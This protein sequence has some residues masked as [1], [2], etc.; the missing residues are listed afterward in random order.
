MNRYFGSLLL[1]GA[2]L[3]FAPRT[4]LAVTIETVIVGNPGNTPDFLYAYGP[5]GAVGYSYRIG[6][7]EV[8]N[9]Q[10]TEFLN[11]KATSDPLGLYS[12]EMGMFATG[13]GGIARSGSDGN[14]SYAT[15][16][17]RAE[18]PV[19]NVNWYQS[20]RFINWL[21]NG[22]GDG[23]TET[24]S[25]TLLGGT[26]EPSNGLTITRNVG[27]K[28]V[29]PSEDEW[30]KAAYYDPATN[31]Y[32]QYP[33]SSDVVPAAEAPPG[34]DNSANFQSVANADL[35][36]VGA[37]VASDSPY[38]AFDMGGNVYEWN[39]SVYPGGIPG[40]PDRGLRG[41]WYGGFEVDMRASTV[42][43][44]VPVVAQFNNGFRIAMI[45]EPASWL[46]VIA[47]ASAAVF[48]RCR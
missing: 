38:G 6:K 23:D 22:Q 26:P 20:I 8:T 10:Y 7:Y 41:G 19:N 43:M 21:N 42:T 44:Q 40:G 30:Y 28:V 5:F 46:L 11:A 9:A 16:A 29:L 14:Y 25:Y 33:T 47:V 1:M 32:F 45:P 35:T 15:I 3:S 31:T 12:V 4:A 24:G 18:L 36:N 37:Y 17:N 34:G 13:R 39:E 2:I 27:A 48:V